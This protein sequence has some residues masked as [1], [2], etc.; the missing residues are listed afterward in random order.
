MYKKATDDTDAK[1]TITEVARRLCIIIAELQ[2]NGRTRAELAQIVGVHERTIRR[3][4]DAIESVDV[5]YLKRKGKGSKMF[6]WI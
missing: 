2:N 4:I 6:Y 3:Y 1:M 5:F